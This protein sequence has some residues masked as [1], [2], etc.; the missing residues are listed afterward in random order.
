MGYYDYSIMVVANEILVEFASFRVTH[1]RTI[2]V[3]D[4]PKVL[5]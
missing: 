2:F 3:L 4:K 1:P 5:N